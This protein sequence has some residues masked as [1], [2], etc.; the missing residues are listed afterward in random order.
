M[1]T[2]ALALSLLVLLAL[3]C[4]AG[5]G[6]HEIAFYWT[7]K[8]AQSALAHDGVPARCRGKY[9]RFRARGEW[10]YRYFRCSSRTAG[11]FDLIVR[12]PSAYALT[13]V[14]DPDPSP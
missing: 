5:A 12:G 7:V 8:K 14:I 2:L 4:A 3:P 13:Q 9:D 6:G 1:K 11:R 10:Y